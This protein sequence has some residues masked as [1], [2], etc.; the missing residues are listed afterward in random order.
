MILFISIIRQKDIR[1]SSQ[2]VSTLFFEKGI[3]SISDDNIVFSH[4]SILE[5]Y[6]AEYARN[7]EEFFKFRDSE[8]NR[9]HFKMRYV[10]IQVLYQIAKTSRWYG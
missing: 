6:L 1:E 4:T 8:N 3:L 5:F 7:N 9:I 10:S 2:K